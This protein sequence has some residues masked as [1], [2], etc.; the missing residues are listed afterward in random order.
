MYCLHIC[1]IVCTDHRLPPTTLF[2]RALSP[3]IDFHGYLTGD[4]E[5]RDIHLYPSLLDSVDL[6]F[7]VTDIHVLA[8]DL[9][10]PL[11][12]LFEESCH[13]RLKG[14][15][16]SAR[17]TPLYTPG[18]TELPLNEYAF[19]HPP[20]LFDIEV[21]L[22]DGGQR[23]SESQGNTGSG[24]SYDSVGDTSSI[25][26]RLKCIVIANAVVHI[27]DASVVF[28][29]VST[30]PESPYTMTVY[31]PR[32]DAGLATDGFV[33]YGQN[34]VRDIVCQSPQVY[35]GSINEMEGLISALVGDEEEALEEAPVD[36]TL[37]VEQNASS[38]NA[39]DS[40]AS[41]EQKEPAD[42]GQLPQNSPVSTQEHW[43]CRYRH[44]LLLEAKPLSTTI[45]Y[46]VGYSTSRLLL[47]LLT[48]HVSTTEITLFTSRKLLEHTNDLMIHYS[49]V[50]NRR[51][52][53]T[54][55]PWSP[56]K[57]NARRWWRYA[58]RSV[59]TELRAES[60]L[61]SWGS[62]VDAV[63]DRRH[64]LH[65]YS[66]WLT[67]QG[68]F[69][70]ANVIAIEQIEARTGRDCLF[71]YRRFVTKKL[72]REWAGRSDMPQ[73]LLHRSG[74]MKYRDLGY[75]HSLYNVLV[76][77]DNLYIKASPTVVNP[78]VAAASELASWAGV[79]IKHPKL[80]VQFQQNHNTDL[81]LSLGSVVCSHFT[82][83]SDSVRSPRLSRKGRTASGNLH[84]TAS[85][86]G[87]EEKVHSPTSS[88]VSTNKNPSRSR[89]QYLLDH[90]RIGS[91]D[92]PTWK[93]DDLDVY[94][95]DIVLQPSASHTRHIHSFVSV[96]INGDVLKVESRKVD[97]SLSAPLLR[98][99]IE[100]SRPLWLHPRHP[101]SLLRSYHTNKRRKSSHPAGMSTEE[102]EE[103]LYTTLLTPWHISK[104][105]SKAMQQIS[106][107]VDGLTICLSSGEKLDASPYLRVCLSQIEFG[108]SFFDRHNQLSMTDLDGVNPL[109]PRSPA[110]SGGNGGRTAVN[111]GVADPADHL[112]GMRHSASRLN[113]LY[114]TYTG[115]IG[116][117]WAD[118]AL[119]LPTELRGGGGG[120]SRSRSPSPT[121][122]AGV[123]RPTQ[124]SSPLQQSLHQSFFRAQQQQ[125]REQEKEKE[126]QGAGSPTAFHSFRPILSESDPAMLGTSGLRGG[127]YGRST[128]MSLNSPNVDNFAVVPVME[129]TSVMFEC[130]RSRVDHS[131]LSPLE[132]SINLSNTDVYISSLLLDLGLGVYTNIH[133][134]FESE[135]V[136]VIDDLS[137]VP[138]GL[139]GNAS[140][141]IHSIPDLAQ[142]REAKEAPRDGS[143]SSSV[144]HSV[145]GAVSSLGMRARVD[146]SV[147][148]VNFHV[149]GNSVVLPGMHESTSAWES[150]D[151]LE[152]SRSTISSRLAFAESIVTASM[153]DMTTTLVL[154]GDLPP[155]MFC[156]V[157]ELRCV[158]VVPRPQSEG[159]VD[160]G[161]GYENISHSFSYAGDLQSM[162]LQFLSVDS[163]SWLY[164]FDEDRDAANFRIELSGSTAVHLDDIHM[165]KL[166]SRASGPSLIHAAIQLALLFEQEA[167]SPS[168]DSHSR[169]DRSRGD[170]HGEPPLEAD[171]PSAACHI[172]PEGSAPLRAEEEVPSTDAHWNVD[173][174]LI[175]QHVDIHLCAADPD[176]LSTKP[177]VNQSHRIA[178]SPLCTLSLSDIRSSTRLSSDVDTI[179]GAVSASNVVLHDL[180][181]DP[182]DGFLYTDIVI[183][184]PLTAS[185][186][187][188]AA[189]QSHRPLRAS[190]RINSQCAAPIQTFVHLSSLNVVQEVAFFS[191]LQKYTDT[192]VERW[193]THTQAN[194]A[195]KFYSPR[196]NAFEEAK[197]SDDEMYEDDNDHPRGFTNR[198]AAPSLAKP[199][200]M[201]ASGGD[202]TVEVQQ[203]PARTVTIESMCG[204]AWKEGGPAVL[205]YSTSQI[206]MWRDRVASRFSQSQSINNDDVGFSSSIRRS[207]LSGRFDR[208]E[209]NTS[210]VRM[211]DDVSSDEEELKLNDS[212]STMHLHKR[213]L[214]ESQSE[215][216]LDQLSWM[217]VLQGLLDF[218]DPSIHLTDVWFFVPNGPKDPKYACLCTSNTVIRAPTRDLPD[219]MFDHHWLTLTSPFASNPAP[220]SS[221]PVSSAAS[222]Q[223]PMSSVERLFKLLLLSRTVQSDTG[224]FSMLVGDLN[225]GDADVITDN[226]T[227]CVQVDFAGV[228]SE[229]EVSTENT[230]LPFN[231][232]LPL[233]W[234]V[235]NCDQSISRERTA[236]V[237]VS[238]IHIEFLQELF[239]SRLLRNVVSFDDL[240]P[241]TAFSASCSHQPNLVTP[242]L[243]LDYDMAR[244]SVQVSGGLA[245]YDPIV[246]LQ[247]R[248]VHISISVDHQKVVAR[249]LCK[250]R[251]SVDDLR[252]SRK[253]ASSEVFIA[254]NSRTSR[255]RVDEGDGVVSE[256]GR[257]CTWRAS[258]SRN[259]TA[260]QNHRG[261]RAKFQERSESAANSKNNPTAPPKFV[262]D[263]TVVKHF[264]GP[265]EYVSSL[266]LAS[267]IEDSQPK[268]QNDIFKATFWDP[269]L[270][271]PDAGF[272]RD[273]HAILAICRASNL[274]RTAES[275]VVL[276]G[277]ISFWVMEEVNSSALDAMQ[278][279]M[280]SMHVRSLLDMNEDGYMNIACS[281]L[282]I[283]RFSDPS[284]E[285]GHAEVGAAGYQLTTPS[286]SVDLNRSGSRTTAHCVVGDPLKINI[287]PNLSLVHK[288]LLSVL[289][290]LETKSSDIAAYV[291]T[292][293]LRIRRNSSFSIQSRRNSVSKLIHQNSLHASHTDEQF[294]STSG[295]GQTFG[296]VP[297]MQRSRSFSLPPVDLDLASFQK[298]MRK[299]ASDP[300][301]APLSPP[302]ENVPV[303]TGS[304]NMGGSGRIGMAEPTN[305]S[306]SLD[307]RIPT[308]VVVIRDATVYPHFPL[309][310]FAFRSIAFEAEALGLRERAYSVISVI[311]RL[312]EKIGGTYD[313]DSSSSGSHSHL[314]SASFGRRPSLD[315]LLTAGASLDPSAPR[316][317]DHA[318]TLDVY[319]SIDYFNSKTSVWE[320]VVEPSFFDAEYSYDEER[321]TSLFVSCG[322]DSTSVCNLN[323]STAALENMSVS[324]HQTQVRFTPGVFEFLHL[325][326][327]GETV[328][329]FD[330]GRPGTGD[331][332]AN[333]AHSFGHHR[334]SLDRSNR[335]GTSPKSY[336]FPHTGA[337]GAKG[338]ANSK[339]SGGLSPP[340]PLLRARS[341]S[342][343][344]IGDGPS[345][346]GGTSPRKIRML[347][348][349][350][351]AA[352]SLTVDTARYAIKN[353]TGSR[354]RFWI[355]G[356]RDISYVE[357]GQCEIIPPELLDLSDNLDEIHLSKWGVNIEMED[358]SLLTDINMRKDSLKIH[359]L[360]NGVGGVAGSGHMKAETDGM[361]GEDLDMA[362]TSISVLLVDVSN[363]MGRSTLT[364]SSV[365][366]LHNATDLPLEVVVV[367]PSE[368]PSATALVR[369]SEVKSTDADAMFEHGAALHRSP[370]V[371][372]RGPASSTSDMPP[373]LT[374]RKRRHSVADI[375]PSSAAAA[376]AA[377]AAAAS[378]QTSFHSDAESDGHMTSTDHGSSA[379]VLPKSQTVDLANSNCVKFV[380][381]LPPDSTAR[382]PYHSVN[383]GRLKVRPVVYAPQKKIASGSQGHQPGPDSGVHHQRRKFY[384]QRR[385]SVGSVGSPTRRSSAGSPTS[386]RYSGHSLRSGDDDEPVWRYQHSASFHVFETVYSDTSFKGDTNRS[387]DRKPEP[388]AEGSPPTRTR[389]RR[390]LSRN[391]LN[392]QMDTYEGGRTASASFGMGTDGQEDLVGMGEYCI[393]IPPSDDGDTSLFLCLRTHSVGEIGTLSFHAPAVMENL[394]HL[395]M[396]V[397]FAEVD[398]MKVSV[399]VQNLASLAAGQAEEKSQEARVREE[400]V[401]GSDTVWTAPAGRKA[402]I[403][404]HPNCI[405]GMSLRFR[406]AGYSWSSPIPS[407][408]LISHR[409]QSVHIV[410][411]PTGGEKE[412]KPS[413]SRSNQNKPDGKEGKHDSGAHADIEEEEEVK[414]YVSIEY[415]PYDTDA[416]LPTSGTSG[417]TL[418][419]LNRHGSG[420]YSHSHVDLNTMA[421][422]GSGQGLGHDLKKNKKSTPPNPSVLHLVFYSPFWIINRTSFSNV[423]FRGHGQM[424]SHPLRPF[425]S[426]D[427]KELETKVGSFYYSLFSHEKMSKLYDDVCGVGFPE[428][429][430]NRQ[431]LDPSYEAHIKVEGS[432]WSPAFVL[433][434]E[435]TSVRL[436]QRDAKTSE[437]NLRL[438]ATRRNRSGWPQIES[439]Q[440]MRGYEVALSFERLPA[441]FHRTTLV[442]LSPR[443]IFTNWLGRPLYLKQNGMS[444]TF[445]VYPRS[446]PQPELDE[447]LGDEDEVDSHHHHQ[448]KEKLWRDYSDKDLYGFCWEDASKPHSVVV[449]F[450]DDAASNLWSGRFQMGRVEGQF[451]IST[452]RLFP[453]TP[454]NTRKDN[455]KRPS[456]VQVSITPHSTLHNTSVIS[457]VKGSTLFPPLRIVNKSDLQI[458]VCQK[459]LHNWLVVAPRSTVSYAWDEPNMQPYLRVK[460]MPP[461][462]SGVT[463]SAPPPL[464]PPPSLGGA[465]GSAPPPLPT[466]PSN[467]PR[468]PTGLP[469]KP[470]SPATK[471]ANTK[472]LVYEY[473]LDVLQDL[474][475]IEMAEY[476]QRFSF[477]S[478]TGTPDGT[479]DNEKA[480]NGG[481]S[482]S[483]LKQQQLFASV[484]VEGP[485]KNFVV[486]H[487]DLHF[488]RAQLESM[489]G[490]EFQ[491]LRMRYRFVVSEVAKLKAEYDDLYNNDAAT[492]AVSRSPV[493]SPTSVGDV[494][495]STV[496]IPSLSV[497][498]SA[499]TVP[500]SKAAGVNFSLSL[501]SLK[502]LEGTQDAVLAVIFGGEIIA[503]STTIGRPDSPLTP[504][505]VE[506]VVMMKKP[507]RH[508]QSLSVDLNGVSLDALVEPH[509]ASLS[510]SQ[511]AAHH[512]RESSDPA[513]GK[514]RTDLD[515]RPYSTAS[516][517]APSP[518][519]KPIGIGV[520][521]GEDTIAAIKTISSTH[522][523]C[524]F[525]AVYCMPPAAKARSVSKASTASPARAASSGGGGA[526]S[527]PQVMAGADSTVGETVVTPRRRV[528]QGRGAILGM[529]GFRLTSDAVGNEVGS[530]CLKRVRLEPSFDEVVPWTSLPE[531][532]VLPT[533]TEERNPADVMPGSTLMASSSM[534]GLSDADATTEK[535]SPTS[536]SMNKTPSTSTHFTPSSNPQPES[537]EE[538]KQQ[539]KLHRSSSD[540]RVVVTT[541]SAQ[542]DKQITITSPARR[543][544]NDDSAATS[545]MTAAAVEALKGSATS[546]KDL[547]KDVKEDGEG[548]LCIEMELKRLVNP[549]AEE[550]LA[551]SLAEKKVTKKRAELQ[552]QMIAKQRE[553]ELLLGELKRRE[554]KRVVK[555]RKSLGHGV[556]LASLAV[557]EE[558]ASLFEPSRTSVNVSASRDA[559]F[560]PSVSM[561]GAPP[562]MRGDQS[563]ASDE[564]DEDEGTGTEDIVEAEFILSVETGINLVMPSLGSTVNRAA[565]ER[566]V[567]FVIKQLSGHDGDVHTSFTSNS[568]R[569]T[570]RCSSHGADSEDTENTNLFWDDSFK[571]SIDEH[572]VSDGVRH[573]HLVKVEMWARSS[574]ASSSST[575]N[576]SGGVDSAHTSE[577]AGQQMPYAPKSSNNN[578]CF[579]GDTIID[580]SDFISIPARKPHGRWYRLC[581]FNLRAL[582]QLNRMTTSRALKVTDS[583][584]T[585]G[586]SSSSDGN[587]SGYILVHFQWTKLVVARPLTSWIV[588]VSL[589]AVGIS[590][591]LNSPR[592][593]NSQQHI[594]ARLP[595]EGVTPS[596][597]NRLGFT[598]DQLEF[599]SMPQPLD[600][601]RRLSEARSNDGGEQYRVKELLYLSMRGILVELMKDNSGSDVSH[602][603]PKRR[604]KVWRR[605]RNASSRS[606]RS[607]DDE[608][609][610]TTSDS[611]TEDGDDDHD[612]DDSEGVTDDL[613][614]RGTSF[615]SRHTIY[616]ALQSFQVDN[617]LECDA[618]HDVV[619]APMYPQ[620]P[621]VVISKDAR[622]PLIVSGHARES[623]TSRKYAADDIPIPSTSKSV[624]EVSL[625]TS[626]I[627][628]VEALPPPLLVASSTNSIIAGD[629]SSP[630]HSTG[631]IAGTAMGQ[632]KRTAVLNVWEYCSVLLQGVKLVIQDQWL[633]E[634][635]NFAEVAASVFHRN[636]EAHPDLRSHESLRKSKMYGAGTSPRTHSL[637]KAPNHKR[638]SLGSLK[639]LSR[640]PSL[641]DCGLIPALSDNHPPEELDRIVINNL[642][643]SPLQVKLSFA[644]AA[645]PSSSS[646]SLSLLAATNA[647]NSISRSPSS[648]DHGLSQGK[649]SQSDSPV[650]EPLWRRD[651]RNRIGKW[652]DL[653]DA[654]PVQSGLQD[655]MLELHCFAV[656]DFWEMPSRA[657]H[658]AAMAYTRQFFSK[659]DRLTLHYFPWLEAM[660]RHPDINRTAHMSLKSNFKS[661]FFEPAIGAVLY[662]G[663]LLEMSPVAAADFKASRQSASLLS[664]FGYYA[665]QY[666]MMKIRVPDSSSSHPS[667]ARAGESTKD[668]NIAKPSKMSKIGS[669]IRQLGMDIQG[670]MSKKVKPKV[671]SVATPSAPAQGNE[672][673]VKVSGLMCIS[674]FFF[675]FFFFVPFSL[676]CFLAAYVQYLK[677]VCWF[678]SLVHSPPSF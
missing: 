441:P 147:N 635:L 173:V 332:N 250:K 621:P 580:V 218:C 238:V 380:L 369:L 498:D 51:K 651:L 287:S 646:S 70:E 624:L 126:R 198:Q 229:A 43:T 532:E 141:D 286:L 352:P 144:L 486:A 14:V 507:P 296:K 134:L 132:L 10:I 509:S 593:L 149:V 557:P 522:R 388:G 86:F 74:G 182:E 322:E 35:M 634:L 513:L 531:L 107:E 288:A 49:F 453:P 176:L 256:R 278:C 641:Y 658:V 106:I 488:K 214:S 303:I 529:C 611:D 30:N 436:V 569:S 54:F 225:E 665:E 618:K 468:P 354:F 645:L 460:V 213:D 247:M 456:F 565:Q 589:P 470:A 133:D 313:V 363:H 189:T 28:E 199:V 578:N 59:L 360:S 549:S 410:Q 636:W 34:I 425:N 81:R 190:F 121:K 475:P 304:L 446:D 21:P 314:G 364:I 533:C 548:Q 178:V 496:D 153:V 660:R 291:E 175:A 325:T 33:S 18:E 346:S 136:D 669:S 167:S 8:A 594:L 678:D 155:Q 340:R 111:N 294:L 418:N 276:L 450:Q 161:A 479:P 638:S 204:D 3:H 595:L 243:L 556:G 130:S 47:F 298:S 391:F 295:V 241:R 375:F 345:P 389:K 268:S 36:A 555:R 584:V 91:T 72:L 219:A 623:V 524:V 371:G 203:R 274:Y 123:T 449:G 32:L 458:R 85:A 535:L 664:N 510:H 447:P 602:R 671:D 592:Y 518:H 603:R 575:G 222:G 290:L 138:S 57:K 143:E 503:F 212:A 38:T 317:L 597:E 301:G 237:S 339:S 338:V 341:K 83:S 579:L 312:V 334:L 432:S 462:G 348:A 65:L 442:T 412:E 512:K 652:M 269:S 5:I 585:Q 67:R 42:L 561:T 37:S 673:T 501:S 435:S 676:L 476:R 146:M 236:K 504:L 281:D 382:V 452:A 413:P 333:F 320:P 440:G 528:M 433:S 7:E 539:A 499:A 94:D 129:K 80:D 148:D 55:R 385:S 630:R 601:I 48:L 321:G 279:R 208:K 463:P 84:T 150:H 114:E 184:R 626:K 408:R 77:T 137:F 210:R 103:S 407:S 427:R 631:A 239:L 394:M 577:A 97:V 644:K 572:S 668:G 157:D 362:D 406:V 245:S 663:A 231:P 343:R 329:A 102:D 93:E 113:V 674:F 26:D 159:D 415:L 104:S 657:A 209:E 280:Q 546:I 399:S 598:S 195:S 95:I 530:S 117:V 22:S 20:R 444:E 249:L 272:I 344:Y 323:I 366:S 491:Q 428:A 44:L 405:H 604:K 187:S 545:M 655:C 519:I 570:L 242:L 677:H 615:G 426:K 562:S 614:T 60:R 396:H 271:L 331:G 58:L 154:D 73:P 248:R 308:L 378:G 560:E 183:A 675:F 474:P 571:F 253:C 422:G 619:L 347:Q 200:P 404:L 260:A 521:P 357:N 574:A 327:S 567:F 299:Q 92:S 244:L 76:E 520:V 445:A 483:S 186:L 283:R 131:R 607:H 226:L 252:T 90:N 505:V 45:E 158:A 516:Q 240:D 666:R 255:V 128:T 639:H 495:V 616:V 514:S 62:V 342:E 171:N 515:L 393:R 608:V 372:S 487:E 629:L 403:Y 191:M 119:P 656:R 477:A 490:K 420:R 174:S 266:N 390:S 25:L 261:G 484:E 265:D 19:A 307:M 541:T 384:S 523:N 358:G 527:G 431:R 24:S 434:E 82:R 429:P 207:S 99:A 480:T 206:E 398:D 637:S 98:D 353:L 221:E 172:D 525:V 423:H 632:L 454:P 228:P 493:L 23:N 50:K 310:R 75:L 258:R 606:N 56:V 650:A 627:K 376:A 397:S 284:N 17:P 381:C 471:A 617:M 506:R 116:G 613:R 316:L 185:S 285:R 349:P 355:T 194:E 536:I 670:L 145:F 400:T 439:I 356:S 582:G 180:S 361:N 469:P 563:V 224:N 118:L 667:A 160:L 494:S 648:G 270:K 292:K 293:M 140:P 596:S 642:L 455:L 566:D 262:M 373:Q 419:G 659:L 61:M 395:P 142:P 653:F 277:D 609:G 508:G 583:A 192:V 610:H 568:C 542:R 127:R 69:T 605:N 152:R 411:R 554:A 600:M 643:L 181:C 63:M 196:K 318:F 465:S 430:H 46:S 151:M 461:G 587:T 282:S 139:E 302:R 89:L 234:R 481:D 564:E 661:F 300:Q 662:P 386:N 377:S 135:K 502:G 622:I 374:S 421:T 326:G 315:R 367:L 559:L 177:L 544:T 169:D 220:S 201:K 647:K 478:G 53:A 538:L 216:V 553:L 88:N 217:A 29:D 267:G 162:H 649:V 359:H 409:H 87:D 179:E 457:F 551:A 105:N 96:V 612:V 500:L 552:S 467:G 459:G 259:N 202:V 12:N 4:V 370:Q 351:I 526:P 633:A 109:D 311:R 108:N 223:C 336:G 297:P 547:R 640:L 31:V 122:V 165:V 489:Q 164:H 424:W 550:V 591:I 112:F 588:N 305:F 263:L 586:Q 590:V 100:Y 79:R 1:V 166:L 227:F 482:A 193:E 52:F 275:E 438:S 15:V 540:G 230:G 289:T 211:D 402:F 257:D 416:A 414:N 71:G 558:P 573:G 628:R 170:H 40:N 163:L 13:I 168:G 6:P 264:S 232:L 324:Y 654:D 392:V 101:Q 485:T 387:Q 537:E 68:D 417:A 451:L 620:L 273:V 2:T 66:K 27:E 319:A 233:V 517:L 251:L 443:F 309:F 492:T 328:G 156:K 464:P 16:I 188:A 197:D 110:A 64:Y 581:N 599:N 350:G 120:R 330:S 473:N 401:L 534:T 124:S 365:V 125:E 11:W 39:D 337:I 335:R 78:S 437:N 215:V 472:P 379:S 511:A 254:P 235:G 383:D 466:M 368:S 497:G 9:H 306:V 543:K 115:S 246:L 205:S 625:I 41:V 448:E 576:E 672:I